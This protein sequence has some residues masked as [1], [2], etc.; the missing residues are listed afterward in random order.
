MFEK[1]KAFGAGAGA[2]MAI[3]ALF[4][5]TVSFFGGHVPPW[6]TYAW[7]QTIEQST[8]QNSLAVQQLRTLIISDKVAQL[9]AYVA[10]N[11][12]DARAQQELQYWVIQLQQAMAT[13]LPQGRK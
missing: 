9:R 4:G 5:A 7:S 10:A 2:A 1:L 8:Q 13:T 6:A 11:P 3:F 12:Q